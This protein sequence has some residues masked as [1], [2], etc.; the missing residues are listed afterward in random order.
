MNR[1]SNQLQPAQRGSS[2]QSET[3]VLPR[4]K[5]LK[6]VLR[7]I[8]W[9]DHYGEVSY[10]FQSFYAGS[11]GRSAKALYYRKPLLGR[12]AVSPIVFCEAFAP[13]A[14]RLFWKPQRFPIADAHY[15]MGFSYLA[16]ALKQ[17]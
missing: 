14:R 15:A 6:A 17:E 13:S 12:L 10:D 9:L 3:A 2:V 8:E 11:F 4:E 1:V 7:F 5:A 16:Q